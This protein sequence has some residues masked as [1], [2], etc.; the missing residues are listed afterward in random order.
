MPPD[1]VHPH[2]AAIDDVVEA[3]AW[4]AERDERVAAAFSVEF[5]QAIARIG[6]SPDRWPAYVEGTRRYLLSRFPFFV[7]YRVHQDQVQVLAVAHGRRR[8][9]Y[10]RDRRA[11]NRGDA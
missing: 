2:P 6:E 1:A 10:W 8:P 7:V 11:R 5:E 3:R 4:Y 9:S